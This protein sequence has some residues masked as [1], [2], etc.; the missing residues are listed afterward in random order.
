ME[1]KQYT[2]KEMLAIETAEANSPVRK[3][4]YKH[5]TT[6]VYQYQMSILELSNFEQVGK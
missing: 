5:K 2:E 3:Q 6:G 4:W 1:I